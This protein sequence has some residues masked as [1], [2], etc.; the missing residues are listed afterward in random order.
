MSPRL[1][2]CKREDFIRRLSSLGFS[3]PYRGTRH[4]FMLY[5]KKRQT[6]PSDAEYPPELVQL[7]LREVSEVLGRKVSRREWEELARKR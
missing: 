2:P 5:G 7:L 3:G 6:I 4:E 1:T